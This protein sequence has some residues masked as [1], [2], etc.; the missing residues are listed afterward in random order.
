MPI[1]PGQTFSAAT[2]ER[3]A[4]P[5][6][7]THR[8]E[9]RPKVPRSFPFL[10]LAHPMRWDI[11]DGRVVPLLMRFNL[12]EGVRG[13]TA[14]DA[15]RLSYSVALRAKEDRGWVTIPANKAPDGVNYV[16]RFAVHGGGYAHTSVFESLYPGSRT[17]ECDRE[18][19]ANWLEGLMAD[20]TIPKPSR[21]ALEALKAAILKRLDGFARREGPTAQVFTD[22]ARADLEVVNK[23][24]AALAKPKR[25][26]RP[27]KAEPAPAVD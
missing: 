10:F 24:I 14:N 19:M 13:I 20:G 18:A 1:V 15:G 22:Q 23:A 4:A 7:Y 25:K 17:I 11:M 9:Q 8:R 5:E 21:V 27:A 12:R 3:V 26:R 2:A 6:S 16:Q